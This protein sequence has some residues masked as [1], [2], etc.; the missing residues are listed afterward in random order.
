MVRAGR[1]G[2][3]EETE[4]TATDSLV[5]V[6]SPLPDVALPRLG[7]GEL[8]FRDLRGSKLLLYFWG[9]W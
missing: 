6:G 1:R 5:T 3:L 7:G 8:A 9:S 4:M 2:R